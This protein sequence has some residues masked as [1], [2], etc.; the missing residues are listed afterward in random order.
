MKISERAKVLLILISDR[1]VVEDDGL[2]WAPPS[3]RFDW[4]ETLSC[5]I[6][7]QG[8]GDSRIIKSLQNKGLTKRVI[9]P[10]S[11]ADPHYSRITA[12]GRELIAQLKASGKMPR[13]SD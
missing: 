2:W 1:S 12:A 6:Y 4:C 8:S 11:Y 7:I 5:R 10:T 9:P 13:C 3:S